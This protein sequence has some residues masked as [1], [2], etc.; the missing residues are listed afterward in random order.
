NGDT[1]LIGGISL[2]E[3]MA[4]PDGGG[5]GKAQTFSPYGGSGIF[6][7]KPGGDSKT[8]L[9]A[10][11][12]NKQNATCMYPTWALNQ[13]ATAGFDPSDQQTDPGAASDLFDLNNGVPITNQ[14]G[15][16]TDSHA[17]DT[18][19]D[20]HPNGRSDPNGK[21]KCDGEHKDGGVNS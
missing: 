8:L 17:G 18:D 9:I 16:A 2:G 13:N 5:F 11:C 14:T 7:Y 21:L 6:G 15:Y 1:G 20:G 4:S 10:A 3:W 19:N 12:D